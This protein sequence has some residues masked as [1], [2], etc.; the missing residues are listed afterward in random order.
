MRLPLAGALLVA[1]ALPS[2][3]VIAGARQQPPTLAPT[4]V[5]AAVA[6][7][8]TAAYNLDHEEAI[9]LARHAITLDP[10]SSA[11]HRALA[12][13]LWLRI[14]FV[15]GAVTVDHYMGSLT[16]SQISLPKPPSALADEFKQ[17]VTRAI[18]LA[19][20][21]L[22]KNP[23]DLAARY[24]A[25]AAYGLQASYVASVEGSVMSAFRMAKRAF[26]AQEDVLDH[27]PSRAEAGL[28]VGTY[29]YIVS[30]LSLPT[31]VLAYIVGFGG[32]KEKGISLIEAAAK[33]AD[34]HVDADTALML[35]YSREGRHDDVSRIA[36]ELHA[37]FPRNRLFL[38]EAGAAAVRAG[39]AAEADAM[40]TRG[41]AAFRTDP[42]E[43]V[44]GEAALWL[45][46]RGMARV[47]LNHPAD[48]LVDLKQALAA[49][50]VGW[51]RGRIHLEL[52]K[53]ADLAGQRA[54][55]IAEYR[56]AKAACESNSDPIGAKEADALIKRPFSFGGR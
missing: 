30:A 15:R 29:R 5:N 37:Q 44:P 11:A 32:G 24:D 18:D 21:R 36:Q 43:K 19:E 55:A 2:P 38:L 10:N 49:D 6:E 1:I 22:K 48:A 51:V 56:T 3:V 33:T 52:G 26:D 47:N 39:R 27:D 14:L 17:E 13:I 50:P 4:P 7:A 9:A 16:R 40:L 31:R 12:S 53:L 28:I 25:G 41:L 42:R 23:R 8:F 34:N 54:D 20:A 45:Y 35:I 46:K